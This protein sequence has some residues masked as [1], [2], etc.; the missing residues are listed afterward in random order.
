MA[1][2]RGSRSNELAIVRLIKRVAL[3]T[4]RYVMLALAAAVYW[5]IR[6]LTARLRIERERKQ[7]VW[8]QIRGWIYS[9]TSTT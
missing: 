6:F 5:V 9:I 1:A 4:A 7:Q 2:R 8:W 3:L